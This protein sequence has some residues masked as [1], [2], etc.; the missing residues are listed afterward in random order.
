MKWAMPKRSLASWL[1]CCLLLASCS[2][3]GVATNDG[4]VL[5][6]VDLVDI[7]NAQGGDWIQAEIAHET[8]PVQVYS[9]NRMEEASFNRIVVSPCEIT[10]DQ[11]HGEIAVKGTIAF[12]D[13]TNPNGLFL[14]VEDAGCHIGLWVEKS[15]WHTWDSSVQDLLQFNQEVILHG[16]LTSYPGELILEV[17]KPPLSP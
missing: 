15:T 16:F 8:R 9:P 7:S 14:D 1:L 5:R 10:R 4:D 11:I 12:L 3:L 13:G 2:S 17:S 6:E